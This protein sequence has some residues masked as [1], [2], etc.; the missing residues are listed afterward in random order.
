ML[1][2]WK[3]SRKIS[4]G[5]WRVLFFLVGNEYMEP[6]PT[7]NDRAF[8]TLGIEQPAQKWNVKRYYTEHLN[9]ISL[10]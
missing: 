6:R 3:Q 1:E 4:T 8:A 5:N 7:S 10:S 2:T 9:L